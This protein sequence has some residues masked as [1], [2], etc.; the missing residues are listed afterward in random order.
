VQQNVKT[1]LVG[2]LIAGSTHDVLAE[3]FLEGLR[4][5]GYNEGRNVRLIYR[6]AEGRQDRLPQLAAELV[7]S[8]VDVIVA[9]GPVVW[10]AKPQTIISTIPIVIAFSGDPV[11]VGIASSLAHTGSNLTGVSFMSS[12]LAEAA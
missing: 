8:R 12:D 5:L 11:G 7:A 4:Q 10:A 2:I 3:E 1:P 6:A 9:L